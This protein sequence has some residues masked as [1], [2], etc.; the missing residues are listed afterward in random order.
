MARKSAQE[1][2][3]ELEA[4]FHAAQKKMMDIKDSYLANHQKEYENARASYHSQRKKL[5][6]ASKK[7]A[8]EA[9]KF[10]KSGTKTAQN[11]LKK[12]RA[13]AV[14]L[15]EALSEASGIMT[16]AQDQLKSARPFEK[17]LAARARALAAF[18]KE[19]EKKQIAAEKAKAV[20]AKKRKEAA[21]RKTET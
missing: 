15:A 12:A 8:K 5:E 11:Q 9:A 19:W 13:A 2:L 21:R 7:V 1:L 6:Q 17:K 20:R 14:I 18:E 4:Q 16:T 3:E 10:R